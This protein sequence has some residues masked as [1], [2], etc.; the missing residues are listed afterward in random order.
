MVSSAATTRP[1]CQMMPPDGRRSP[2]WTATTDCAASATTAASWLES[3]R[4]EY[5]SASVIRSSILYRRWDRIAART[6]DRMARTCPCMSFA[7]PR[8]RLAFCRTLPQNPVRNAARI[9]LLR[10]RLPSGLQEADMVDF[11]RGRRAMVDGQ[12]GTNDVT[13]LGL[14]AVMLEVPR[15]AFVPQGQAALAYLDRDV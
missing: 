9:A 2:P 14:I 5:E 15:E 10:D 6:T 13:H 7:S 11:A 4:G 12:V 8:A 1:G 3:C